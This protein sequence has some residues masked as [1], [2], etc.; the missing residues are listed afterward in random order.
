MNESSALRCWLTA[1]AAVQQRDW[2]AAVGCLAPDCEWT[3]VPTGVRLVG[4]D[5]IRSFMQAGLAAGDRAPP[6]IKFAFGT[7]TYGV[8]EYVSRGVATASADGFARSL[9]AQPGTT[10]SGVEPS[11]G[12]S[13]EF[14]VCFLFRLDAAGLIAEVREY[15]AAPPLAA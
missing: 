7:E 1:S 8:F 10:P 11:T 6:E 14:N 5:A 3:L 4:T 13:Y 12:D 9:S 15:F 2:D